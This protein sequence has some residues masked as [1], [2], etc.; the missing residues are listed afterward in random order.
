MDR[1]GRV[2]MQDGLVLSDRIFEVRLALS[3][4]NQVGLACFDPGLISSVIR[5]H[6]VEWIGACEKD[7]LQRVQQQER[8]SIPA[9]TAS[10][11]LVFRWCPR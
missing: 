1:L 11:C 5:F 4:G 8:D 9:I 6:G 3:L 7:A 2:L 10:S